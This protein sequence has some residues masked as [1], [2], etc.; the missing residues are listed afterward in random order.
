M[1]TTNEEKAR[2]IAHD[3]FRRGQL[4][5]VS[6]DTE[7]AGNDCA[8]QAM[9]WKDNQFAEEKRQLIDKAA[10]WF[11]YRFPNISKEALEKFKEDMRGE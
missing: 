2:E 10:E 5:L 6:I 11:S 1:E 4:G 7:S 3:Y 8:M 9:R